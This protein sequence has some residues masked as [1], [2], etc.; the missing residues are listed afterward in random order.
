MLTWVRRR[1]AVGRVSD[2]RVRGLGFESRPGTWRRNSGQVSH[3][4]VPLFTKQYKL[5][6][7]GDALRL[8]SKG[9]YGLCVGGR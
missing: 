9:R 1:G 7:G 5:V 6:P 3:T 4:C 8:G 2:L